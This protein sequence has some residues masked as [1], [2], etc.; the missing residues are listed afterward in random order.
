MNKTFNINLG[1][2]PFIV[3][4]AAYNKL[5]K[6][7]Q[8]IR[9][10]FS[11][12]ESFEE[13][14]NDIEVRVG[15]LLQ[16]RNTGSLIVNNEDID[17]V[18]RIMGRPEDFGA[19]PMDDA[20]YK[21][22]SKEESAYTTTDETNY[23]TGRR[24]FRN[25]MDK[26]LG[27]VCS[28]LGDYLGIK[29]NWIRLG[30]LAFTVSGGLGIPLYFLMWAFIPKAKTAADY[31][32]MKGENASVS[33]IA[34]F[35]EKQLG[36]FG[37]EVSSLTGEVKNKLKSNDIKFHSGE[38]VSDLEEN[39]RLGWLNF[40]RFLKPLLTV[41][42]F[43][44][45]AIFGFAW[46]SLII[47]AITAL[48]FLNFV[49]SSSPVINLI[50][51]LNSIVVFVIPLVFLIMWALRILFKSKISPNLRQS[52]LIFWITNLISLLVMG[53][54]TANEFKAENTE[55]SRQNLGMVGSEGVQL[56]YVP[57]DRN[58]VQFGFLSAGTKDG[59]KYR[60]DFDLNLLPAEGN[61]W[62]VLK[63]IKSQ[64]V[65]SSEA[66]QNANCVQY[67]VS[68]SA[69][70]I[71]FPNTINIKKDCKFRFQNVDMDLYIPI[72]ATFK[73]DEDMVWRL[74]EIKSDPSNMKNG[75]VAI[76][77]RIYKMTEGGVQ[78]VDC[79]E[80]ELISN[81]IGDNMDSN[82]DL[83]DLPADYV[84]KKYNNNEEVEYTIKSLLS[85]SMDKIQAEDKAYSNSDNIKVNIEP[86]RDSKIHIA[87]S[88]KYY[89]NQDIEAESEKRIYKAE[90][91]GSELTLANKFQLPKKLISKN[92]EFEITLQF[93][94]GSKIR[95]SESLLDHKGNF[96]YA[97]EADNDEDNIYEMT[98]TGLKCTNCNN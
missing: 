8:A 3:D 28:G 58:N 69:G 65:N 71:D 59:M 76:P 35:F 41:I 60:N 12:N 33:G 68:A 70:E 57:E 86:A 85:V 55:S 91:T 82:T 92:P 39:I 29:P 50:S 53:G 1:G 79:T 16:E 49:T 11:T 37:E 43:V 30:F 61:Q 13:I 32:A 10:H 9:K 64:G 38:F 17:M 24:L 78:C 7:L 23:K 5:E 48:P 44:F 18:I 46:V 25:M 45:L 6:Y 21:S 4:D 52:L 62:Y 56:N 15:E 93:P 74:R 63:K 36:H 77:G 88:L 98:A 20:E 51:G 67:D 14:M 26:K 72:G 73:F 27:G 83:E 95:L 47:G 87:K 96:Q 97:S 89:S 2:L 22:S 94:I 42:A 40:K 81:S 19:E 54:L 90:L 84:M 34:K 31:L 80:E 66:L 75:W